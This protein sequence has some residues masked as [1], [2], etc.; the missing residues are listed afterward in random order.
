MAKTLSNMLEPETTN[1]NPK[2]DVAKW[3]RA[4][5]F[6]TH[7]YD[8]DQMELFA[9]I[10]SQTELLGALDYNTD[11][12][13]TIVPPIHIKPS[14]DPITPSEQYGVMRLN[15][16]QFLMRANMRNVCSCHGLDSENGSYNAGGNLAYL[17]NP[18]W[19]CFGVYN[20]PTP[21]GKLE[22]DTHFND[23]EFLERSLALPNLLATFNLAFGFDA[24]GFPSAFISRTYGD[25]E[26]ARLGLARLI[27]KL[28]TLGFTVHV[29]ENSSSCVRIGSFATKD[30]AGSINSS[31]FYTVPVKPQIHFKGNSKCIVARF[32][33]IEQSRRD[34]QFN[35]YENLRTYK[36]RRDS[37]FCSFESAK[38]SMLPA[39]PKA[40]LESMRKIW[41]SGD[42]FGDSKIWNHVHGCIDDDDYYDDD[43]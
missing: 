10:L 39:L 4:H 33:D 3:W 23:A 9:Y 6:Q 37:Y 12:M 11:S 43:Y 35:L 27:R 13:C 21:N 14:D 34:K 28:F 26:H 19:A 8:D 29:S 32:D 7:F 15:L 30:K 16:P 24:D 5:K 31:F 38:L 25:T 17:A 36:V 41:D 20:D 42:Y 18:S 2:A 1:A 40:E 22:Y